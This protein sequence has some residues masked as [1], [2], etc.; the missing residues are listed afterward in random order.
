MQ[1]VFVASDNI[2]SPLGFTTTD[3]ICNLKKDNTGIRLVD[4][5]N[6]SQTP[7][8]ASIFET[9]VIDSAF[10]KIG[11]SGKFTR[12]EKLIIL[13]ISH[14]IENIEINIKNKGTLI[15]LSTTKGNVN[16]LE[17]KDSSLID[18]DRV[19]LWRLAEVLQNFFGSPNTPVIISNACISGSLAI[20]AA[21]RMLQNSQIKNVI[22]TGGDIISEFV[23]SGFQSFHS[24]SEK[25]CKPFDKERDGL[26]LGEGC[27]TIVLTS[28]PGM[29]SYNEKI[30]FIGGST[31]NDANHI[32]GPSRNGEGLY[33]AIM[34]TIKEAESYSINS[35]DYISAHGTATVYND[36]SESLAINR[37]GLEN[38]PLN[39]L[40][41]FWGHTLG[42]AGLIE[43]IAAIQS[44][45]ENFLINTIGYSYPGVSGKINVINKF[46]ECT[47]NS[48]I[49]TACGF[50][51]CN[52]AIAFCK[53]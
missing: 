21:S 11:N 34:K 33:L 42:A 9:N 6:I 40:K 52:A 49:K 26:S 27:G 5:K 31:S 3:N 38:V 12:L 15:V 17:E 13:S 4:D 2:V 7:F 30:M 23:A 50:G 25:P 47:L 8:Y 41:G 18:N 1:N 32:S 53:R 19:Y 24:I 43:T 44:L 51:G 22:V 39:S 35:F 28:E 46:T 29:I 37:A 48:L 45:K 10:S 36:E 14:A 20:I 16:L